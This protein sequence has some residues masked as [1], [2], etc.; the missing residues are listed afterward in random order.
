[1]SVLTDFFPAASGGGGGAFLSSPRQLPCRWMSSGVFPFLRAL[2]TAGNYTSASSTF[3]DVLEGNGHGV[4]DFATLVVDQ[5]ETVL[6][7]TSTN[8]G[9][10]HGAIAPTGNTLPLL[11]KFKI[12]I[13]GTAYEII[14]NW[15]NTTTNY[16]GYPIALIG[17]FILGNSGISNT[18][19][20]GNIN[21]PN[22]YNV[23]TNSPT[24][25]NY[26]SY[27]NGPFRYLTNNM[28]QGISGDIMSMGGVLYKET[29]KVEIS[30]SNITTY[31][32]GIATK[33]LALF[34]EF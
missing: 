1:M 4:Y 15:A 27:T 20:N 8:G 3:W 22:N 31:Q 11:N 14:A 9:I 32:V 10:F 19:D 26:A 2:S 21:S 29:L 28:K 24:A 34:T 7:K 5:Y 25:A 23:F 18:L 16:G 33:S 13:D 12:T 6:D 17:N 30:A